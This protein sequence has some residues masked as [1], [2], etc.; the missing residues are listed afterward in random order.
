MDFHMCLKVLHL[1]VL[2]PWELEEKEASI[3]STKKD[4]KWW[5]WNN[6]H[7]VE[8]V[9]TVHLCWEPS[10]QMILFV[11]A[12]AGMV[13]RRVEGRLI[14]LGVMMR[15]IFN[16]EVVKEVNV[17]GVVSKIGSSIEEKWWKECC[18]N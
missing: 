16:W 12:N 9:F 1:S 13:K 17:K 18:C 3:D 2:S 4:C 11:V 10:P 7:D 15:S 8:G 5:G 6:Y 14:A